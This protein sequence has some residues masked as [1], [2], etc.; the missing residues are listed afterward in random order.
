MAT[1]ISGLGGTSGF[2]ENSFKTTSGLTGNLDDVSVNVNLTSVFGASGV[3]VFGTNYTSVYVNSNGL[4]TFGTANVSYTPGGLSALGYPSIAPFWTDIDITKGGDIFWDLDPATGKVTITWSNVAAYSGAGTDSFQVI[5]S[6]DGSGQM[7]VEFIYQNIGFTNGYAG[8]AT[9]GISNGTGTQ[10]L[11][12]GSNNAAFLSTYANNDFDV[13]QPTGVY[14]MHFSAS[15]AAL[16]GDGIVDGSSGGDLIDSSYAGDLQ[17]DRVDNN[18][19]VGYNGTTGND[20]Y[21][22]AGHGNDTVNSGAGNDQVY[23]GT[24]NDVVDAGAGNDSVDGGSGNDSLVGGLG[25]DTLVGGTATTGTTYTPSYT[26]VT[27]ASQSVAG[28]STRAN[29]T[30]T[31][32]SNENNLT[33]ATNGTL[34]GYNLGNG[35]ANE[36][37]THTASSQISGGRVLFNGIN[38]SETLTIAIDGVTINLN[39]A[40]SSGLV[41]FDGAGVYTI[42]AAGRIV[43]IGGGNS[44]TTVG[45]LTVNQPYTTMVLTSAGSTNNG[46]FYEYYVNTQP[47]NV[48]AEAGGNDTL[49]GGDGNDSLLGGDG[50]DSLTGDA[51]NDSLYGGTGNDTLSG[52]ANDD[53]LAG[54]DGN[55]S[56]LGGDGSD[57]LE[58]GLGNDILSGEVGNDSLLGEDGNDTLYGGVGADT[59]SGGNNDDI[60]YGGDGSDLL[61]GDAGNDLLY[62][63]Q[64]GETGNDSLYGGD[65]NDTLYG[66]AADD[67]LSGGANDDV[68]YGGDGNDSLLGGDGTD[69]LAGGLGNDTLLGEVGNDSLS[70]DDGNDTLYGGVGTDTLGGGNNDD[71]LY[72]GDG[73]DLLNGDAGNDVLYGDLAGET[74]NDSLVGGSGNDQLYGGAGTDSMSGSEGDDTLTGGAGADSLFGD[75]GMDYADYSASGAGVTVDLVAG[76]GLGGDAQGDVLTGIDGLFGSDFND[77]LLG[78]DGEDTNPGSAYT[79]IFYGGLGND[80]LDGRGGSDKLYGGNDDD[81]ISGG[82]GNDLIDGG[83]GNDV[84]YGGIGADTFSGGAGNDTI[85]ADLNSANDVV[86]GGENLDDR[87]VLDLGAW[88]WGLTNVIYDPFNSENGTVEFLDGSGAVIST[89]AFSNIEKVIPCFTPGVMISTDHGEVAVETLQVGDMVLTRDHGMRP[90]RWIGSRK[91]G[92]GNLIVKPDLRPVRIGQGA[93]GHGLPL[94]DTLVSPQHRMLIESGASEMLF[95]EAEVLVAAKELTRLDGVAQVLTPGVTYIHVMFDRHEIVCANGSWTESFQPASRMVDQMDEAQYSE[96]MSIF[97]D[98]ADQEQA[99]PAARMTLKAHEARVLLSV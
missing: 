69:T 9:A 95:G 91:L 11:L 59:L 67:L 53:I 30:V 62:G 89:M 73:S 34:T 98:L 38:S 55:D 79:N 1:M 84:L 86:E 18:D 66:G 81:T 15:G 20:D 63:D 36:A 77:I 23:G 43:R 21:I 52:G 57:T 10:A 97:P 60:L 4:L 17:G 35:D 47:L 12:E 90:V 31:T 99:F 51:G 64:A 75:A 5:L 65:G 72:G 44:S 19:A 93:L 32:V 74:G 33:F 45:T 87:D 39:T 76:T 50:N 29:F 71:I 96:I 78:F 82:A 2:G 26:E 85:F 61:N 16:Y 49:V 54:G 92:L 83:S 13:S 3:N 7:G 37:H 14:A 58:G 24:G 42:D 6:N 94:R 41:T 8:D 68:L 28:T 27:T 40:I 80:S 70:G 25:N 88:G 48:A 56:L 22:R 46:T